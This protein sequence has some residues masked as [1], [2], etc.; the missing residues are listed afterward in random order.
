MRQP[1]PESVAKVAGRFLSGPIQVTPLQKDLSRRTYFRLESESGERLVLAAHADPLDQAIQDFESIG[2]HMAQHGLPVPRVLLVDRDR[3]W[4]LQSD[5]GNRDLGQLTSGEERTG[6]YEE[7][8]KLIVQ[9]QEIPPAEPVASRSFD[10]ARLKSEV[11]LFEERLL[12][13]NLGL[14]PLPFELAMFMQ[15]VCE[16]LGTSG[17]LVFTHRDLHSKNIMIDEDG[18]VLLIDFQDAR[19]G[20]PWYDVASLVYDPYVDLGRRER[21]RLLELYQE[22]AGRRSGLNLFYLQ[23]L[24]RTMK[25]M[26]T[27]LGVLA[28]GESEFYLSALHRAFEYLEEIVQLGGFPDHGFV[29]ASESRRILDRT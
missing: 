11:H 18:Q 8:L 15:S 4:V 29:F 1:D 28:Q 13:N 20:L 25:A 26:G 9:M 22:R 23:A 19:M 27:Y 24:Q 3:G 6:C 21:L 12:Q 5:A 7:I 14:P 2:R 16:K 10:S 17:G